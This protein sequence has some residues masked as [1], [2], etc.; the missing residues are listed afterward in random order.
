ML[1]KDAPVRALQTP[2]STNYWKGW[3][4]AV[5][6]FDGTYDVQWHGDDGGVRRH[7]PAKQILMG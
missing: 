2:G 7:V 5:N 6:T 1:G 3:I 4:A